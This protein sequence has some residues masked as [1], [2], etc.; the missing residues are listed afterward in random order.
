[1]NQFFVHPSAIVESASVGAGTRVWAFAHVLPGAVIGRDCNICDHV[2][3]ENEV[4]VG[5]RVTIKCGVQLWDGVQIEDDVFVGPN[6]TFTNDPFPRSRC[7]PER[8]ARTRVRAGASIG[9]NATVLPGLTIGRNAMVGAGAVVTFDVPANAIVAGNPAQI[10]GYVGSDPTTGPRRLR[11]SPDD[12]ACRVAGANVV[13]LKAAVDARGSLAVAEAGSALPFVPRRIFFVYDV[14]NRE[15]RG[16]H[17]HREQEQFLVCVKGSCSLVVDDGVRREELR[18][19]SPLR[20]VHL[21]PLVWAVQ[22]RFSADAVL[23]VA[24]SGGYDPCEYIRDYEEF[25]ALART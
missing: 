23:A 18:L 9:A 14:P 25:R 1:M 17:A 12:V 11:P 6:V 8:F 21:R 13:E 15:V 19:D 10:Q 20:G 4:Q 7:R 24:A 22:Y 16:E 3:V 2:F 5:D